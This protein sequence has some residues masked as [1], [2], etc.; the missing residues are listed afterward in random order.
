M[1]SKELTDFLCVK[2]QTSKNNLFYK[3]D[4][5]LNAINCSYFLNMMRKKYNT[6]S[7]CRTQI[8]HSTMFI[9]LM[10]ESNFIIGIK[11]KINSDS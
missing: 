7:Y 3:E 11:I 10:I 1:C 8:R 2:W 9:I 4:A 6:H 5:C